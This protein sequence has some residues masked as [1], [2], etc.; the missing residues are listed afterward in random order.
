MGMPLESPVGAWVAGAAV[1]VAGAFSAGVGVL[2]GM[3]SFSF[4]TLAPLI[5]SAE[6]DGGGDVTE[7]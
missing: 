3:F 7:E 6:T 2:G 5:G 4:G 1:T